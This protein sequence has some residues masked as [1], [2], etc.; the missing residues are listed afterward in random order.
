MPDQASIFNPAFAVIILTIVVWVYMY[1][2]RIPFIIKKRIRLKTLIPAELQ[3]WSP[4]DVSNPSDNLKNLFEIPV[5][6]YFTT[7]YLFVTQQVDQLY[8]VSSWCFAI[9]RILHSTVHCSFNSVLLR[10]SLYVISTLCLIFI[11]LRIIFAAA[12]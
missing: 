5:I 9:F 3:K 8:L 12:L 7:V 2:K 6:F 4:P 11:V 10:F 1:S